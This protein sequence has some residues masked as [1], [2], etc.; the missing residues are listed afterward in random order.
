MAGKKSTLWLF[1]FVLTGCFLLTPMTFAQDEQQLEEDYA[2]GF[3]Y[4]VKKGDTLWDLSRKFYDSE[5]Q[6]PAMWGQNQ[7]LTNPH[8][9]YPGQRIRLYQRT[10]ALQPAD[11]ASLE[12]GT[13]LTGAEGQAAAAVDAAMAEAVYF[14]YPAISYVGFVQKLPALK[15]SADRSPEDPLSLGTILKAAGEKKEMISQYDT[16]YIKPDAANTTDTPF[17]VGNVYSICP[18]LTTVKDPNNGDYAG[19]Q[20]KIIG[21]AEITAIAPEF[22]T[23]KINKALDT[24]FSGCSVMPFER[25]DKEIAIV[26]AAPGLTGTLLLDES[27]TEMSSKFSIVFL[28]KGERDGMQVG[29]RYQ[30]YYQ[31]KDEIDG[32]EVLFPPHVFGEVL[33]LLTKETT[34]SAIV[35]KSFKP[36]RAGDAFKS[37]L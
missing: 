31:D 11:V 30:I 27:H 35:T 34:A 29:Q 10:D 7:N 1:V 12:M 37:A 36:I 26:P 22:V 8:L 5:W 17:I 19:H 14:L 18:P 28:N 24:I 23:A 9:I 4:T 15:G 6:W 13:D 3:Y 21:T 32:K 20:Y 2:P 33:V 25:K 16:V